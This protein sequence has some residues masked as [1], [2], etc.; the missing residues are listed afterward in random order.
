[1]T[2]ATRSRVVR[3]LRAAA[4]PAIIALV[5][6]I[7]LLFPPENYS[8]YP[9]CP[10]HEYLHLQCPGCGATRALAALLHGHLAEAMHLNALVT[11]LLPFAAAYCILCYY[12][13]FLNKP[14]RWP[15]PP[16]AAIYSTLAIAAVFTILRNL[17]LSSL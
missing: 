10:I 12:R 14:Q 6:T 3:T 1:M 16:P 15:Q 4:P 2:L 8:F 17:S 11:P 7:L 9:R 13:L 5:A